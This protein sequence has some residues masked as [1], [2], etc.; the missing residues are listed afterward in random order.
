[1]V[2]IFG[3]G[4]TGSRLARR[5]LRKKCAPPRGVFAAA[6]GID[7]FRDLAREGLQLSELKLAEPAPGR[8]LD[9][10][11]P[12]NQTVVISIPPLDE[13]ENAALHQTIEELAP[14]RIVYISSTGVYGDQTEVDHETHARPSDKRGRR[15]LAEEAWVASG[16][17]TSVIL[18]AAA[19]YG[20]G[21]GVHAAVR[22]GKLPRG[23]NSGVTSR[24]HVD[25]LARIIEA[26]IDSDLQGAWP[27]ADENPCSSREII[28]WCSKLPGFGSDVGADTPVPLSVATGRRVNAGKIRDILNID[29]E[30]PEWRTGIAASIA[31]EDEIQPV[32]Q[33]PTEAA[34]KTRT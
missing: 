6:R 1:M 32:R 9:P 2:E 33:A 13:P 8:H 21:R 34:D 5:L 16:A 20:P 7:R 25:D 29:L 19:I 18:R 3:L 30:Y 10:V 28:E 27:V 26:V 31:E 12:A 22:Q 23:T 17:W 24:I 4:F 15:R 14:K 11:L